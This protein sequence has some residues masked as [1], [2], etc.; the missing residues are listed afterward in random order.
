MMFDL[1][2][3][4]IV[5]DGHLRQLGYVS[6]S[7]KEIYKYALDYIK[8]EHKDMFDKD[9]FNEEYKKLENILNDDNFDA[10]DLSH[11][12]IF[13]EGCGYSMKM[14]ALQLNN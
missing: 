12:S 14:Y 7:Y 8:E 5:E 6:N 9:Y 13:Y 11:I 2:A 4:F 3:L 1:F 10:D